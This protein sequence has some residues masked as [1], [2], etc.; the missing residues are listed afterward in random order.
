MKKKKLTCLFGEGPHNY[1]RKMAESLPPERERERE[2]RV[3]GEA[4]GKDVR[5]CGCSKFCTL[6]INTSPLP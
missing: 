6:D 5:E 1:G 2:E 4:I 3:S